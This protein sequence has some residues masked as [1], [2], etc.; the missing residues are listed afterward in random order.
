[1]KWM[2]AIL[3][4]VALAAGTA[5]DTPRTHPP[6]MLGGYRV[7]AAD[8]HVHQ[9][10]MS[11]STLA[12]WDLV[13]EARRQGLDAIAITGHN[14][15]WAGHVGR[16][17]S[18]LVGGPPVL[19]GEEVHPPRGH[20]LALGIQHAIDWR[21]PKEQA[22]DEIHRQ[23]GVAIAAHPM[24]S[25]WP[26]WSEVAVC[27]LDGVEVVH[28]IGDLHPDLASEFRQFY[29]RAPATAVG[30]SDYHGLGPLGARR[31]YVLA[32]DDS[33]SA[34]LDALRAGRTVVYDA[35][36]RAFG[37]SELIRLAPR[38][39]QPP[40]PRDTGPLPLASRACGIAGLLLGLFK[41]NRRGR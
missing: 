29:D 40:P 2:P 3:V 16:W 20:M 13:F 10:P 18:R 9:F 1:M 22:I 31:T 12:P 37:N 38:E 26:S 17:F 32:R 4:A 24:A 27:K 39:K 8:F 36:G 19:V 30:D 14:Q 7:L 21:E 23:G 33:E 28:P 5:S 6:L 15:V 34:I 35:E 41:G 25:S 11:W